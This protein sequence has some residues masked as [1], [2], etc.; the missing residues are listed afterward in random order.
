[1]IRH[2][3]LTRLL[4]ALLGLL[5]PWSFSPANAAEEAAKPRFAVSVFSLGISGGS[6]TT[7]ELAAALKQ[8][9]GCDAA[10]IP[11]SR[12][13][14]RPESLREGPWL[15]VVLTGFGDQANAFAF[16]FEAPGTPP[17]LAAHVP[18]PISYKQG[19]KVW[20]VPTGRLVSA[21]QAFFEK[22]EKQP[23]QPVLT[24]T[25]TE[26]DEAEIRNTP[27][28]TLSMENL[29]P[30]KRATSVSR[31]E[32][33]PSLE[34]MIAGA[35]LENGLT[36]S[37][38]TADQSLLAEIRFG[39]Q[40]NSIRLTRGPATQVT[41]KDEIPEEQYYGYLTRM[42]YG[43]ARQQGFGLSDFVLVET[44]GPAH[45]LSADSDRLCLSSPQGLASFDPRTGLPLDPPA[46][47][48]PKARKKG[49]APAI[50]ADEQEPSKLFRLSDDILT[51]FNPADGAVLWKQ[52]VGDVLLK[53]PVRIG[54]R[55]LVVGK[56]NR[57]LLLDPAKGTILADLQW[58]T[59]LIDVIATEGARPLIA[60]SDI[61][62]TL[63]LLDAATL[64]PLHA[65]RLPA[66]PSGP[67]LFAPRFPIHWGASSSNENELGS[68]QA[69]AMKPVVLA[70]DAEGFCSIV[71]LP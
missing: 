9:D 51:A 15:S 56:N 52:A 43:L 38:A 36:P 32:A 57:I 3:F 1:M 64:K 35:M 45:L 47:A 53:E 60:C 29:A 71:P 41:G 33:L 13:N 12:W 20:Y 21:I 30:V 5:A 7:A 19:V 46:G 42:F 67:L 27:S 8:G 63:S 39:F 28:G 66:R 6:L 50:L 23:A 11:A 48:K 25:V 4:P 31:Q 44:N 58:P 49:K 54:D 10:A 70:G 55:V 34:A 68:L 2:S 22:P 61:H 17:R 14:Q 37:W 16:L 26:R 40:A 65:L 69:S 24:L 18:Y 59:W 62:G